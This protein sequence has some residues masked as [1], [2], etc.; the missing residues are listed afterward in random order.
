M[1]PSASPRLSR[2]RHGAGLGR[3][4]WGWVAA[5]SLLVVALLFM[6]FATPSASAHQ[7]PKAFARQQANKLM[8]QICHDDPRPCRGWK[9]GACARRADHRVDCQTQYSYLENN[10]RKTCRMKTKSTL[11]GNLVT[12]RVIRGT[13]R[14]RPDQRAG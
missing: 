12:T 4:Q 10:I 11:N 9:V 2:E 1:H 5:A 7:L 14:C 3:S 6:A 8:N 13:V